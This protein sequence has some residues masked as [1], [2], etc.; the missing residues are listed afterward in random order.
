[1][2]NYTVNP[3]L[4]RDLENGI[5]TLTLNRPDKRNAL[6][7]ELLKERQQAF[8]DVASDKTIKVIILAGNGPIF[9]SGHDLKEM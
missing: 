3:L 5:C 4:L 8:D 6:S 2:S 9:C 7:T 1:M